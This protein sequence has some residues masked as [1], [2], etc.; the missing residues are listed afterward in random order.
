VHGIA[1]PHSSNLSRTPVSGVGRLTVALIAPSVEILG[2]HAIQVRALAHGL[3]SESC[4]V[5]FVPI[6]PS[7]PHGLR[8]L[9]RVR[10]VRT[11]VNEA[12]Y[13]P[14]LLRLRHSD[15]V[16]IF[17]ASYWGFVLSPLPAILAARSFGKRVVL[18]YHSGEA[19]DHLA[20]WG[21]LVHPWLRLVDEIVVP[22]EYLR[23]VF[24][25]HGYQTRVIRNV[26]DTSRFVYRDRRPL[27]PT[28]LSTRNLE[29]HY[30]V[31]NTLM[32][33]ARVRA[34]FPDATLTVAG[35]GSQEVRLRRLAASLGGDG[36][37]FVGRV[38][39]EAMPR[40]YDEADIFV[41]S[42][43]IDNQPVS[44][45]EAFAAGLPVVSTSTG[46]LA[47]L[48]RDGETGLI[49]PPGDPDA[50]A[51]AVVR[52]LDDHERAVT[53][54]RRAR[55]EVER[56]T[57]PNVRQEWAAAYLGNGGASEAPVRPQA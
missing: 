23:D 31:D 49:T 46:D 43:V 2:G 26:V 4:G 1:D 41:N 47:A 28:L 3:R 36:I 18:H 17:S 24:A 25:R 8:W 35:A 44:V 32:A 33:F 34:R 19:P 56:Y 29:P 27:R 9:R 55:K 38:E 50:M 7:L 14:T 37:R 13:I 39:P 10:Y 22:S 5:L 11:A 30:G 12:L 51:D 48:V 53:I 16:H 6:N 15:V 42:S 20:R 54:S 45:L 52:L 57:W 40:L 21:L